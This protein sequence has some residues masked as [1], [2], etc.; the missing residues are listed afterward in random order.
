MRQAVILEQQKQ[1]NISLKNLRGLEKRY[2][3]KVSKLKNLRKK[4]HNLEV[5]NM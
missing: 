4:F 5:L 2:K 1:L 3:K